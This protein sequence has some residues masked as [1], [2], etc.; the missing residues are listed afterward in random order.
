MTPL[1]MITKYITT[2]WYILYIIIKKYRQR[3]NLFAKNG[4]SSTVN[5]K[6]L[7]LLQPNSS[8]IIC[9]SSNSRKSQFTKTL[10]EN[11]EQEY[12]DSSS[13]KYTIII[14]VIIRLF[15]CPKSVIPCGEQRSR[16]ENSVYLGH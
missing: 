8:L 3:D 2:R 10:F 7:L 9:G 4:G 14:I 1:P 16:H 11:L 13:K 6:A 15:I 5:V 12:E